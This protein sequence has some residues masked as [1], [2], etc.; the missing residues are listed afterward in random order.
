MD[1][2]GLIG[3]PL[4]HSFSAKYF[5]N[6]FEVERINAK[7]LNFEI[8]DVSKIKD[9][10]SHDTN[11][12][13]MNVTIPHKQNVIAHLDELSD[14][15]KGMGAVNVIKVVRSKS[16]KNK[17]SLIGYN[18][19]Y[20]GFKKSI[21]PLINKVIHNKALVLGTGG[22][23][24]AVVYA[25]DQMGIEW[26]YVSRT[27][28]VN[29]ITYDKIDKTIMQSHKVIINCSPIGTYPNIDECPNLPYHLI[30]NEHLLYDLVYNPSETLFL[31]RGKEQG[32]TIKNGHEMLE[33]Q[34]MAAWEIWNE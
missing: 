12:K 1:K 9:I 22:A 34:A 31:K 16:D 18:T 25:L 33:L 10:V 28:G 20:V 30:S 32:A 5:N 26:K 15:A 2:Y 8:E 4:S 21:E 3:F 11:L 23:S 27:E 17:Y 14:D 13:G 24:K 29:R 7:Y 19:D 6:K